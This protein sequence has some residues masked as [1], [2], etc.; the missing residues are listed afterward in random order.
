MIFVLIFNRNDLA[1]IVRRRGYKLV[2]ELLANSTKSDINGLDQKKIIDANQ[3]A[4][5]D[6]EDK[7]TGRYLFLLNML[8]FSL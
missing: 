3:D 6:H 1:N 5:S 4:I 7:L 8:E 2:R